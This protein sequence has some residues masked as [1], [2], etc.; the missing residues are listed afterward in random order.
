M[1][2]LTKQQFFTSQSCE[3]KHFQVDAIS[4]TLLNQ[5]NSFKKKKITKLNNRRRQSP[6]SHVHPS[7]N[8]HDSL[9][10]L[11]GRGLGE[12]SFHQGTWKMRFLRDMQM[13][14]RRASICIGALLRNLEGIHL[15]G[16][17]RDGWRGFGDGASLSVEA[18]WRE[19]GG[20]LP[21]GDPEEYLEQQ[22]TH[23]CHFLAV[24]DVTE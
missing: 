10:R 2:Q 13:S 19:P 5:H 17:L 18:L 1:Q 16:L 22:S 21:P 14:C 3:R 6:V 4:L 8:H 20:G 23:Q 24:H 15:P 11:R 9:K 12:G 7:C